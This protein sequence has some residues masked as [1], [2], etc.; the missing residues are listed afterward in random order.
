MTV[1][2]KKTTLKSEHGGTVFYFCSAAC[3]ASFDGDPHKYGHPK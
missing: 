1:D 3:K 2:E